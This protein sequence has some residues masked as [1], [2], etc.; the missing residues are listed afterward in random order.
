MCHILH[1]H[2]HTLSQ[3][4]VFVACF[5]WSVFVCTHTLGSKWKETFGTAPLWVQKVME[6]GLSH[7]YNY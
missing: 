5:E 4:G 7:I 1:T 6:N 2:T 3:W